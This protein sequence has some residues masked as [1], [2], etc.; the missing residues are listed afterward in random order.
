MAAAFLSYYVRWLSVLP[1]QP[2]RDLQANPR[3]LLPRVAHWQP[4]LPLLATLTRHADAANDA[5]TAAVSDAQK[6]GGAAAAA[7]AAAA[8]MLMMMMTTAVVVSIESGFRGYG[9]FGRGL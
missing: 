2:E 1:S 4:L 7:A 8:V 6:S 5:D 9:G 3:L